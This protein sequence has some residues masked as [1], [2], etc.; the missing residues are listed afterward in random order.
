MKKAILTMG[1]PAA[2][3][4]TVINTSF[5]YNGQYKM[6]DPDL[7]KASHPDYDPKNPNALH[8]WSQIET[9]KAV[10]QY[11]SAGVDMIIDGTGTNVEKM[12][13]YVSLLQGQGYFVELVY[14]TVSLETSLRRNA[15][16]NRNVPESVVREKASTIA[17]AFELIAPK[18]DKVTVID[19]EQESK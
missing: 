4:S 17:Y 19:N 10:F 2:G 13:K 11:I 7:F 6:V 18:V 15:L 8:A 12:Y 3:K 5:N 16:R 14:V 9:E 1:L